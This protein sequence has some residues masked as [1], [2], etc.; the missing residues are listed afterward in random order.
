MTYT[1][2][3]FSNMLN[4]HGPGTVNSTYT[5]DVRGRMK[6][7]AI[8]DRGGST[9]SWS[10]DYYVDS[11]MKSQTDANGNATSQTY[12]KLM[13]PLVRTESDFTTK[14]VW[15]TT[16]GIGNL[17]SACVNTTCSSGNYQLTPTYDGTTRLS[18]QKIKLDVPSSLIF[19][20]ESR[21]VP[22]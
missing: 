4:A 6:T 1:Y 14:M 17:Q 7:A 11:T 20:V 18:T 2:D 16:N 13:R 15:D 22:S 10:Y 21:V 12:D 19:C 5:Y 3:A 9:H 8:P